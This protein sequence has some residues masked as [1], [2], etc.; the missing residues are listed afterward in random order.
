M[1]LVNGTVGWR[2]ATTYSQFVDPMLDNHPN[3]EVQVYTQATKIEL[4]NA[5]IGGLGS[6]EARGVH[7]RDVGTGRV[8]FVRA[9]R[10]VVV[11]LGAFDTPLLMELSGIG[12][13]ERLRKF[14]V[15]QVL[16]SPG[17]GN[18]MQNHLYMEVKG[19]PVTDKHAHLKEADFAHGV[20]VDGI[21][22]NGPINASRTL[23]TI[24]P[25]ISTFQSGES[26]I[27]RFTCP[28]EMVRPTSV[29]SIHINSSSPFDRPLV[30]ANFLATQND[31]DILVDAL[32]A[33]RRIQQAL[34]D[35]G[36]LNG[37]QDELLPGKHVQSKEDIE[38][39]IRSQVLDDFHSHG[40]CRMGSDANSPLDGRL[41]VKGTRNLRVVDASAIPA[42]PS[43]NTHTP[44][45]LLALQGAK[46]ILQD[47]SQYD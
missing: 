35:A 12:D 31:V 24:S 47:S 43:G 39:F 26:P 18:N 32:S 29:G 45:A 20:A 16:Q 3:L 25:F 8:S 44:T 28:M 9:R 46:F 15:K 7:L 17:V 2:R 19:Y 34:V 36:V 42:A 1:K 30:N 40:S 4:S 10:E 27:A 41:L 14:G 5:I 13:T 33:C 11:S 6:L 37:T 21:S 22:V 23:W 38:I